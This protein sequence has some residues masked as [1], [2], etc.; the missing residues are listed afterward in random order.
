MG[1]GDTTRPAKLVSWLLHLK[2][3]Y[4]G[5]ACADGLFMN[6]RQL[7]NQDG[8]DW[9][10]AQRLLINRSVQAAV[11]ESDAR[12]LLAE[13]LPYDRCQV[14]V[15]TSMPK[16]QGLDDLYPGS[17]EKMPNYVRTQIDVVLPHGTAV[18]HA[19]DAQVA[20]LASYSDGGVV[21]YADDE[22][23]PRLVAHRE[24]GGRVGFWRDGQ[25]MLCE[26][27]RESMVLSIK[28]PAVARLLQDGKLGTTDMLVAAC[29]AWALDIGTDLIRA[30]V[31]SFGQNTSH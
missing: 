27:Q 20:E 11:F 3:L 16:A 23:T 10:N 8:M 15:V 4:T 24:Q 29:V 9:D 21:F 5:L 26:G 14:G 17:D 28:R 7:Q 6:Q 18:L 30:G 2:G 31:K 19:A 12:H 1:N 25:L 13:G 22:N